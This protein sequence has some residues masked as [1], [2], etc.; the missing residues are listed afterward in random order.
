MM[1]VRVL[2]A[3][4]S[5]R[6]GDCR[7][8]C[9]LLLTRTFAFGT[10][11]ITDPCVLGE[12]LVRLTAERT[13]GTAEEYRARCFLPIG[14][15]IMTLILT[16]LS[17]AG[18]AMAADSASLSQALRLRRASRCRRSYSLQHWEWWLRRSFEHCP[19]A[20]AS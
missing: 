19:A 11:G 13:V 16:E 5:G 17:E 3:R 6:R 7:A 14:L 9:N 4:G 1:T 20:R 8:L 10:S 15:T 2:V 12:P 18:V